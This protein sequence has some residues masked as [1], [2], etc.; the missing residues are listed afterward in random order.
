MNDLHTEAKIQ[1]MPLSFVK[2]RHL[3]RSINGSYVDQLVRNIEKVGVKAFPL[4]ATPEGIL[5]GGNHRY[6]A[7]SRLGIKTCWIHIYQPKSIDREAIELNAATEEILPMS[8]VDHA[9]LVW[10]KLKDGMTQ[11]Q[12]AEDLGWSR[13]KV[14]RFAMLQRIVPEAW[15]VIVQTFQPVVT[16]DEE[17]TVTVFVTTVTF[18]EN[19]LREIV[20]LTP[21]QQVD[22]VQSLSCGK[23]QKS[24]FKILAQNYRARND[25]ADWVRQQLAGIDIQGRC[26]AE[27]DKGIYDVEWQNTQGPG[28]K[29]EQLV[30]TAR[31]EWER[32]NSVILIHGDFFE[33]VRS[34]GNGSVDLILTDPPYNVANDRIFTFKGRSNISQNFGDWDKVT[35]EDFIAQFDTWATEFC[36]I[37]APHGSG[38]VFTSDIYI[39]DLRRA[40]DRAGLMVKTSIVWQKTNPGTQIVKTNFKSAVEYVLFFTRGESG[41]TFNWQGENEM[42]NCISLPICGGAERLT[43]ARGNTLHPTQKPL[44]LLRHFLEISSHPGDMVFD[45]FMGVGS[46]AHA[47]RDMGRRFIGIEQDSAFFE[48]AQRR[49]AN[50]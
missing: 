18:T 7:F 2:E 41:H 15:A 28:P 30:Q 11:L 45:G 24:R 1:E 13:D 43:D 26:L 5:F 12:V 46:T 38:Y 34:V 10:R 44:A 31:D 19:L 35:P 27:V 40:L 37:L 39:S 32:K 16:G 42:H 50:V 48:A 23:I 22:L 4:S 33:A 8:F 20:P 29:L 17:D 6:E 21:G 14:A 49:M 47:A 3:V 36:R 25:A 9:E